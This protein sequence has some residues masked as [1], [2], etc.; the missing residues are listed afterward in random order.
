MAPDVRA[1][2]SRTSNSGASQFRRGALRVKGSSAPDRATSRLVGAVDPLRFV[3]WRAEI[4]LDA[5]LRVDARRTLHTVVDTVLVGVGEGTVTACGQPLGSIPTK[6]WVRR[7]GARGLGSHL[8]GRPLQPPSLRESP[9]PYVTRSESDRR[10]WRAASRP[11]A[12]HRTTR[13]LVSPR[14]GRC[15]A[16]PQDSIRNPAVCHR[17]RGI[18]SAV[19]TLA[20]ALTGFT[21]LA[22]QPLDR[23]ADQVEVGAGTQGT[24]TDHS[25]PSIS[26]QTFEGT[27]LIAWGDPHPGLGSGSAV[28]YT[29]VLSDGTGRKIPLQLTREQESVALTYFNKRVVVSGRVAATASEVGRAWGTG[30]IVV[31]SIIPSTTRTM[32]PST[33]QGPSRRS[34]RWVPGRLR[35]RPST[36]R[37]ASKLRALRCTPLTAAPCQIWA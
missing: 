23:A 4:R 36:A 6:S 34:R 22:A 2:R 16:R 32:G 11:L 15:A 18:V 8:L 1:T 19:L 20:A 35:E 14:A 24:E 17:C 9:S 29:L 3:N 30:V 31:D 10:E 21:N 27:L 28:R 7:L 37:S 12:G 13:G 26:E 5:V 33:R 25:A